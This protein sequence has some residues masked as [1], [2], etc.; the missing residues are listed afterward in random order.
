MGPASVVLLGTGSPRPAIDRAQPSQLLNT[1]TERFLV[2]CGDGVTTQLLR[3]S[4][5]P[6]GITKL[7]I[8]HLHWDH[9]LGYA[10]LVWGGWSMG[11][12][13]MEVWGPPGTRR[14]HELLF[15]E[16]FGQDVKWI[17]QYGYSRSAIESI[18]IHEV[19]EGR[20]YDRDGVRVDATTVSHPVITYAYRFTFGGTSVVFS[21]DT[22]ECEALVRCAHGADLLVQ[23]ACACRS[24]LYDDTRSRTIQ[25]ALIGFHASPLQAGRMAHRAGV[26]RLACTHLLPGADEDEVRE[27]ASSTYL[28]DI[29]V[30]RDL[31]R[32]EL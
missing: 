26:R 25:S 8:T 1:G 30:G 11:R 20:I 23:D 19:G 16:L 13:N 4:F 3:A 18:R 15:Q 29:L 14:M 31:M 2:D 27:E 28:G 17:Q 21:G 6:G 9:V 32:I 10:P 24:R 12:K 5:D 7:F 22:A